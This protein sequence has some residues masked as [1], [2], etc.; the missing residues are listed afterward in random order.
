MMLSLILGATALA[1]PLLFRFADPEELAQAPLHGVVEAA[2]S[3]TEFSPMDD[4]NPPDVHAGDAVSTVVAEVPDA[5]QVR[6]TLTDA[7]GKQWTGEFDRPGGLQPDLDLALES[8]G[9]LNVYQPT[10][11]TGESNEGVA[12]EGA[13][14]ENTGGQALPWGIAAVGWGLLAVLVVER[15]RARPPKMARGKMPALT[16]GLHR[17]ALDGDGVAGLLSRLIEEHRVV[18]LG[19]PPALEFATGDVFP[20]P[21]M[22]RVGHIADA[23][24]ALRGRGRPVAVLAL[25]FPEHLEGVSERGLLDLVAM[26]PEVVVVLPV[27]PS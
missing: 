15:H 6:I 11:P 21:A 23:V 22:P 13:P 14:P 18:V 17:L 25:S 27:E 7:N 8:S 26:L 24:V 12:N 9:S 5:A 10:V 4:G 16:P 3:R 1:G 2:G 20:L 19:E